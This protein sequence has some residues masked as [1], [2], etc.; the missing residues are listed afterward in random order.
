MKVLM[1]GHGGP[2]RKDD[3]IFIEKLRSRFP[4]ITFE[5]GG[6][7]EEQLTQVVDAEVYHAT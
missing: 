5:A 6:S 2:I 7:N 1:A 3:E 4:N